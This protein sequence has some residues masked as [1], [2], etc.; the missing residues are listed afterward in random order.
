MRGKIAYEAEEK[1]KKTKAATRVTHTTTLMHS[2][3]RIV[4]DGKNAND[5][6]AIDTTKMADL[7]DKVRHVGLDVVRQPLRKLASHAVVP[8]SHPDTILR[9]IHLYAMGS[10]NDQYTIQNNQARP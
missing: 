5:D 2:D 10:T 6:G 8:Q 7:I 3:T 9:T 1:A 4:S